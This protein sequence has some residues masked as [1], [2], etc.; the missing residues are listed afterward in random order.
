MAVCKI[1]REPIEHIGGSWG[2]I[3]RNVHVGPCTPA[4]VTT[5]E[6]IAQ[7]SGTPPCRYCSFTADDAMFYIGGKPC[8]E[9]HVLRA[10]NELSV[11]LEARGAIRGASIEGR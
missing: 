10:M 1:G 11:E 6:L 9:P 3:G 2:P 5:I 7:G 4:L 8:C